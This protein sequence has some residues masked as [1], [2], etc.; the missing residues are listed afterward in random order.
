MDCFLNDGQIN[1]E[2]ASQSSKALQPKSEAKDFQAVKIRAKLEPYFKIRKE[3]TE[4]SPKLINK[5][6]NA[7][8]NKEVQEQQKQKTLQR[9][10]S[11]EMLQNI[12]QRHSYQQRE[13]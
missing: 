13:I 1:L 7:V 9:Q 3:P 10:P 8:Q 5:T 6:H 11:Q 4:I 2:K 12:Y